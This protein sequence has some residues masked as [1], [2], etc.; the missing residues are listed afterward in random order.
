MEQLDF[1]DVPCPCIGLCQV[2]DKGYCLGCFRNRNERF[3]WNKL[4]NEQKRNVIRLC[5]LRKNKITRLKRNDN[6]DKDFFEQKSLF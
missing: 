5:R 4:T 6:I 2:N 3:H 1:F